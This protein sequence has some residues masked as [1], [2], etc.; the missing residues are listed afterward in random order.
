MRSSES[1]ASIAS[2]PFS[3]GRPWWMTALSA[4]CL[5]TVLFLV[6][7]SRRHEGARDPADAYRLVLLLGTALTTL[8]PESPFPRRRTISASC[9]SMAGPYAAA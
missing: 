9:G 2:S 5:L 7:L 3:D 1:S 8:L 4:F 6:A